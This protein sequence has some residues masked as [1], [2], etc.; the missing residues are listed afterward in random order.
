MS[1]SGEELTNF[2]ARPLFRDTFM[3]HRVSWKCLREALIHCKDETGRRCRRRNKDEYKEVAFG[4]VAF[5]MRWHQV[6]RLEK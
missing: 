5:M 6:D 1:R 4:L 3:N 2:A